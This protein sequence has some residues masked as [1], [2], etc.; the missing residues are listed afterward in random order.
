MNVID[1]INRV[2]SEV[3]VPSQGGIRKELQKGL[4]N[5]RV[6]FNMGINLH[7]YFDLKIVKGPGYIFNNSNAKSL[8]D[9]LWD[10]LGSNLEKS[11]QFTDEALSTLK[12]NFYRVVNKWDKVYKYD[13]ENKR[14][15]FVG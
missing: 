13:K 15:G 14:W 4:D 9:E 12:N 2:L 8:A 3:T 7:H 11:E 1:K 6:I 10:R 5:D